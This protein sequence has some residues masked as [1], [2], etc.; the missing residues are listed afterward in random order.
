MVG[1]D[2]QPID[3]FKMV[4]KLN[5]VYKNSSVFNKCWLDVKQPFNKPSQ[6]DNFK[7]APVASLLILA[8]LKVT[9]AWGVIC[10][11]G[12]KRWKIISMD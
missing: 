5:V 11:R 3:E 7:L 4:H 8:S 1:E 12:I 9:P 2:P 10:S 6:R